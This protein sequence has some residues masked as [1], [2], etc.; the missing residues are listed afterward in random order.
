MLAISNEELRKLKD[1]PP[2]GELIACPNCGQDH[3]LVHGVDQHG[4]PTDTLA[5]VTCG[6]QIYLVGVEGKKL[7]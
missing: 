7:Q 3:P 2:A 4:N 6:T 5:F 1:L